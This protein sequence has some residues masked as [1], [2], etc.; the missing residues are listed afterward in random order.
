MPAVQVHL[1][2][3]PY[4]SLLFWIAD[5]RVF[6]FELHVPSFICK[7][8][9]NHEGTVVKGVMRGGK[10]I[11]KHSGWLGGGKPAHFE[12]P[13][14]KLSHPSKEGVLSFSHARKHLIQ[15]RGWGT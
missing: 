7:V 12:R 9:D 4:R 1:E 11:G 14:K 5:R 13:T 2:Q 8:C 6:T 10:N 3:F 15:K